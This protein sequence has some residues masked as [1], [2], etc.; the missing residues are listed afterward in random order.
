MRGRFDEDEMIYE[1][2]VL[3][4][5]IKCKE[6]YDRCRLEKFLIYN[7]V[8]RLDR[9]K[10]SSGVTWLERR[11]KSV[12]VIH[13]YFYGC[14]KTPDIEDY[15]YTIAIDYGNMNHRNIISQELRSLGGFD[16]SNHCKLFL[17]DGSDEEKTYNEIYELLCKLF[18]THLHDKGQ[19]TPQW[20][21]DDDKKNKVRGITLKSLNAPKVKHCIKAQG[22]YYK[23][24]AVCQRNPR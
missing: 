21:Y 3:H 9:Y 2:G 18:Y 10:N 19:Y 13:L 22:D 1:N 15:T 8:D 7:P 14:I 6:I 11:L 16:H 5:D 12:Y 24:R 4:G 23:R 17:F 20:T